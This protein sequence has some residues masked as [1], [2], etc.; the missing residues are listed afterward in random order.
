MIVV[1]SNVWLFAHL[2][3]YPEHK[4]AKPLVE[5]LLTK[6]IV[7][8]NVIILSEVYHKL[9]ILLDRHVAFA[10][11]AAILESECVR[12]I[13]IQKETIFKAVSVASRFQLR[14]NDAL[15]GQQALEEGASVLTDDKR[16]FKKFKGLHVM[17]LRA[18]KD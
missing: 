9:S 2:E 12:C 15:I 3:D 11:V 14:I 17:S 5:R 1:D 18:L 16:S 4:I 13:P 8:T 6:D 7:A 10:K